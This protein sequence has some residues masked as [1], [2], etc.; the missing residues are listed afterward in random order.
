MNEL[1]VHLK[2]LS[3]EYQNNNNY[4]NEEEHNRGKGTN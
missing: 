3:I 4:N 1:I 2:N